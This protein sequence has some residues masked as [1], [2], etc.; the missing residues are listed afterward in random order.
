MAWKHFLD[1]W[2]TVSRP[3]EQGSEPLE[4]RQ[5]ILDEVA[6]KVT[7]AGPGKRIFP[8]GKVCVQVVVADDEER[9]RFEAAVEEAW[10]L[11]QGIRERLT[12]RGAVPP[13]RLVVEIELVPEGGEA[14]G[15]RRYRIVYERE[16]GGGKAAGGTA[17]GERQEA[18]PPAE[19]PALELAVVRGR[20]QEAAYRFTEPRI[21]LGRM[22]EVLD[23]AGRVKRRNDVAFVDGTGEG[24]ER[25]DSDEINR[26]VSREHARITWD[27]D[28]RCFWLRAEAQGV[29]IFRGG[30]PIE[31]SRHDRRGVRLV[32]GDEIY[33]GRASVRVR[34]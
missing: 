13:A 16:P 32:A 8:Y 12:E 31:V 11:E 3:W 4:I 5:A 10:D 15:G 17:R 1:K 25:G 28:E 18:A 33:L 20:A 21:L 29:R 14:F 30:D 24:G 9:A 22:E 7:A 27:E 6:S 2:S 23:E 26:T 19:R 34:W